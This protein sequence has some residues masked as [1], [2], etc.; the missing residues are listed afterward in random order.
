[1]RVCRDHRVRASRRLA[2]CV[3][4][5][6]AGCGAGR[7]FETAGLNQD[8]ANQCETKWE[9]CRASCPQDAGAELGCRIKV[10]NPGRSSC[11][12]GC[13]TAGFE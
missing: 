8:C 6:V 13:P 10:C 4:I 2:V 11:L 3:A 5:L 7:R 9:Q 12:M 1:M